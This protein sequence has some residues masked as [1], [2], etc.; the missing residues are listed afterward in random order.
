V[1]GRFGKVAATMNF[2]DADVTKSSV[3]ATIDV[4]SLSTGET[5]RDTH[6]KTPDFF[7]VEKY[8]SA[9]FT[10][11]AVARDGNGLKIT[12]NLT[13]HGVTKPVVLTV[14]GPTTPVQ[15]MDKKLHSGFSASANLNRL[16]FDIGSK[17]P[18]AVV[19]NKV[20][21]TIELDFAKQ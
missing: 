19:S 10:S 20:I 3:N 4:A 18:D 14:D 12:G 21:L 15:G 7:D 5:P 13:L 9:S 17:F 11:T 8:P 16:D 2:N 6:I 1:H